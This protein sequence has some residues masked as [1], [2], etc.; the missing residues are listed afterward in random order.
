MNND[1]LKITFRFFGLLVLQ[2]FLM[3]QIHFLGYINPMIY[4]LFIFLYPFENNRLL[5]LILAF[6]LGLVMDTFQD[7]GGAHAAASVTLTFVRPYLLKL[8]YGESYKMKNI[9]VLT[10]GIDRIFLLL[11]LCIVIHHLMFYSLVIF[12][13]SQLFQLLKMTLS[14]GLATILVSMTIILL[15]KPRRS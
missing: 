5:F 4:V 1:V 10:T 3:D 2:I 13:S 7:T 12:N 15:I 8:V 9:K 14:V 11:L 6:L